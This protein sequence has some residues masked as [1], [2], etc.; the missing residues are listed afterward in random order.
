MTVDDAFRAYAAE[1]LTGL[2]WFPPRETFAAGRT[3]L[4]A[5][6]RHIEA[7]DSD[8]RGAELRGSSVVFAE[9][10]FALL[11]AIARRRMAAPHGVTFRQ[12]EQILD[13]SSVRALPP[14]GT[15]EVLE[16]PVLVPSV[17]G[18]L[19]EPV[20]SDGVAV[21]A[22]GWQGL[23]TA[24]LATAP[25]TVLPLGALLLIP[26]VSSIV[27]HARHGRAELA[28]PLVIALRA[29]L[30][31]Q[32]GLFAS[33]MACVG[34]D[35]SVSDRVVTMRDI[36]DG[37]GVDWFPP[38]AVAPRTDRAGIMRRGAEWSV[39]AAGRLGSTGTPETYAS[40]REALV[41]LLQLLNTT[42]RDEA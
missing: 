32:S 38:P 20:V 40:E 16:A 27:V 42:E 39:W 22:T 10:S 7:V 1:R 3:V 24:G 26:T 37:A 13:A 14:S 19:F 30:S 11:G 41:G 17:V 31:T 34:G 28:S 2:M 23:E 12:A 25:R 35:G 8:E 6:D 18:R 5:R 33:G 15:R 4:R 29:Y 21:V 36:T 9:E